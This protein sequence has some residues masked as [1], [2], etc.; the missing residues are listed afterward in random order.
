MNTKNLLFLLVFFICSLS[1]A[2][3]N[4]NFSDGDFSLNPTWTESSAGDFVISNNQLQS[5]NLVASSS[6]FITTPSTLASNCQWEFFVNLKFATS[7]A[8]FVDVYLTADNSNLLST[9]LNGYFV[10]IGNTLDEICLYKNVT[11][12]ISKIIDGVDLSVSSG[13]N[14]LIRIKV[15]RTA[16]N[17][18]TLE[19][20]LSGTGNSYLSEGSIT[21]ATFTSSQFFG[22]LVKQSTASFFQKHFFDDIYAGPIILDVTSPSIVSATPLSATNLDVLFSEALDPLSSQNASNYSVNNGTG[23]ASSAV[24]DAVNPSLVHLTFSNPFASGIVSTVSVNN[25]S[26]IALNAVSNAQ[27]NFT[28]YLLA[29]PNIKDVIINEIMADPNPA[30]GLPVAEYIELYNK[31]NS[32]FNLNGWKISDNLTSNST[33][34]TNY[35][36]APN[37]YVIL[38]ASSDT[39]LF[40]NNIKKI[41]LSAYPSWNDAGDVV[42]L[43]DNLGN[44]I[45]SVRYNSSWY[46]DP[47]KDNGGWSLELIN[48]S[49]NGNCLTASN[50]IA[51]NATNGGTPS[52]QNSVYNLNPDTQSPL[53][54]GVNAIDS[55]TVSI[56][57]NEGMQASSATTTTNYSINSG[58]LAISSATLNTSLTCVNLIL[59]TP[60]VSGQTYTL[61]VT[62]INDCIGNAIANTTTSFTFI[63]TQAPVYKDLLINEIFPDPSPVVGLP[64]AE[65]IELYNNSTKYINLA[66][67]KLTDNSSTA[68]LG[69]FILAPQAYLLVCNMVDTAAFNFIPNRVGVSSFPSLNNTSDNIYLKTASGTFIDSVNYVDTW[70]SNAVKKDGGWTLELINPNANSNCDAAA[71]WTASINVSGGTPG[72]INSVYSTAQDLTPPSI[73]SVTVLDSL[74]ISICFSEPILNSSLLQLSNFTIGSGIGTPLSLSQDGTKCLILNLSSPLQNENTYSLSCSNLSDCNG[75]ALS[76]PSLTFT[77][78][79]AKPFDVLIHEIMADPDPAIGLPSS[80]YVELYNRSTYPINLNN[81]LFSTSSSTKPLTNIT[82]QPDSFVV[83][84]TPTAYI[85]YEGTGTP[86]FPITSFPSLTNSGSNLSLRT[87]EGKLIHDVSY[88]INWYAD[89]NKENGGYSLEMID[90]QNPCGESNNWKA[91][92]NINGGTPGNR[93]SIHQ[94]NPDNQVP[95]LERIAVLSNDSI[96]VFFSES[97]DSSSLMNPSIYTVDNGIGMPLQVYAIS[98]NNKS[99]I[100]KLSQAIQARTIYNCTVNQV[101]DCAGNVSGSSSARFAIPEPALPGDIAINEIMFDPNSGGVEWIELVNKSDKTIDLYTLRLGK[102]DTIIGNVSS[103]KIITETGYLFFKGEYLVLSENQQAIKNQYQTENPSA[104]LNVKDLISLYTDDVIAVSDS[105][106]QS[107]EHVHY[108][109]KMHFPLLNMTKGVSLERINYL[110]E[111]ND[112]TNWNSASVNVGFATPAYKNSQYLQEEVGNS[113]TISPEV[114]SPDNDG[115]NDVVNISYELNEPG[116]A[117]SISVFDDRGRFVKALVKNENLGL[118]GTYSWNGINEKNEKAPLGIYVIY[119]EVFNFEGEVKKYKRVCVLGGKL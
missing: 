105:M 76:N 22:I 113:I 13:T 9:T 79:R 48:P 52:Q 106:L 108:S 47:N 67:L 77:Y 70:Y 94:S 71:N 72:S 62:G 45:D 17:V 42:Y 23:S 102:Y 89:A 116:K 82:I 46:G 75:N 44:F 88:T 55:L 87:A 32:W 16:A 24:L 5:N 38:V 50:W 11:G 114:F 84:M 21:D 30:V 81:W 119:F 112:K 95:K 10:R 39:A 83:L 3:L 8:N 96:R 4:D 91:S 34:N 2:Q 100:L 54:S 117:G 20:D 109:D 64:S 7:G 15:I 69:N 37:D 111:A 60:M 107:I 104:F 65:F 66:G 61:S 110:R 19:R 6:F 40:S 31:T 29:T 33:I 25:V 103:E 73:T 63:Q 99:V 98:D 85:D 74:Q 28:Y 56:C 101:S 92:N 58:S 49:G 1:K 41:G 53:I 90:P 12:T 68:T 80:E 18:F 86:A 43:K 59:A 78:Y 27:S 93:N 115:Y 26:D 118:K 51:S 36:L 97:I 14:N 35:L 57:F